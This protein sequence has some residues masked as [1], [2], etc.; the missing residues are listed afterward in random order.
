MPHIDFGFPIPQV[1]LDGQADL[2]LVRR[3]LALGERLGFH[4]AWVQDQVAGDVPLHESLTLLSYASALTT[5]VQLGVSVLVFPIRNAVHVAK[6]VGTLDNLSAGR[7]ILGIGLG[8]VMAPGFFRTYG[9]ESTEAVRRF[10]EGVRVMKSLWTEPVTNIEGEF[11]QLKQTG[12]WP[13]PVQKPHVPLWFGGQ[14]PDAL[15]R[16]VKYADGYTCAGPNTTDHFADFV[17]QIRR[18]L[19]EE[20]RDP[21]TLPLS[22]RVYI[23]IDDNAERAKRRLDEFF[24]ARYPW[25]IERN[26]DFVADICAWGSTAQVAEGLRRLAKIGATTIIANPLWDFEEQLEA[27]AAEVI[28]AVRS[29]V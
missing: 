9:I 6:I 25:Q 2:D 11:Y 7:I 15:R 3:T 8:H 28:P 12:M 13:K 14:H 17:V 26:P 16:A 1:F 4:S 20:G 24:Q 27:L 10:N 19:D 23:G 18:F 22:K 21:A 29:A 5:R